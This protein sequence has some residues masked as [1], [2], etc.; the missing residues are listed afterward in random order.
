MT[1]SAERAFEGFAC[2]N[3]KGVDEVVY[4]DAASPTDAVFLATHQPMTIIQRPM[5]GSAEST[6]VSEEDLLRQFLKPGE[7]MMLLPIIGGS[8]TGKSH[9]V[10]WLRA[11]IGTDDSSRRVVYVPKIGTSLRRVIELILDG[12]EGEQAEELRLALAEATD[13]LDARTAPSAVLAALADR[14]EY[15]PLTT[16]GDSEIDDRRKTLSQALPNL[17]RD[18]FF[19]EQFFLREGSVVHQFVDRAMRG[20]R[21]GDGESAFTFVGDELQDITYLPAGDASRAARE[22]QDHL[23][24]ASKASIAAQLLTENLGPA[25]QS[26]FGLEG[27]ISLTDVMMQTRMVLAERGM[28]LI[29]LIEDFTMLQGIQRELLDAIVEP[30]IRQGRANLCGIRVTLAVTSGYWDSLADTVKTRAG[31]ASHVYDLNIP[32]TEGSDAATDLPGFFARYLNA[33]RVGAQALRE[34]LGD[35][36][37][38]DWVPNACDSCRHQLVCHDSFGETAGVGLYP[39]NIDAIHRLTDAVTEA[40]YFDP[41]AVLG[42]IIKKTL[43]DSRQAIVEGRFPDRGYERQ[44]THAHR[45]QR[46]LPADV[47]L[48][49]QEYPDPERRQV[50]LTIWGDCPDEVTDLAEG[51]HEAFRIPPIG[52]PSLRPNSSRAGSAESPSVSKRQEGQASDEMSPILKRRLEMLDAWADTDRDAIIDEDAARL[53]RRHLADSVWSVVDSGV[54]VLSLPKEKKEQLLNQASFQIERAQGG[55]SPGQ[56]MWTTTIKRSPENAAVLKGIL[57]FEA[58]GTWNFRRGAQALRARL[59]LIDSWASQFRAHINTKVGCSEDQRRATFRQLVLDACVLGLSGSGSHTPGEVLNA[60]FASAQLDAIARTDPLASAAREAFRRRPALIE[61]L[62]QGTTVFRGAGKQAYAVDTSDLIAEARTIAAE[63]LGPEG[64]TLNPALQSAIAKLKHLAGA[65]DFLVEGSRSPDNIANVIDTSLQN[66]SVARVGSQA[67]AVRIRSEI[68]QW[69]DFDFENVDRS[70]GLGSVGP[71]DDSRSL[72][73]W[74]SEG[75]G[76][77]MTQYLEFLELSELF[78]KQALEQMNSR[79]R[80]ANTD[81]GAKGLRQ[82][83]EAVVA[84]L[85]GGE[86]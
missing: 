60:A 53:L 38:D 55:R 27:A 79:V 43:E 67:Q 14:I 8:G 45:E 50:L 28:E 6:F 46:A 71:A 7:P 16:V 20:H 10:R 32:M 77:A 36:E 54:E 84:L 74:L 19:R 2:W 66:A 12:M 3:L 52:M 24:L 72:L 44:F 48:D 42:D 49:I 13:R 73:N 76:Q 85:A 29:L 37:T 23:R 18:P 35:G 4:V 61:R 68:P 5:R 59:N 82:R 22:A 56:E 15:S 9:L 11:R 17:L 86:G 30:P 64:E 75:P 41:R 65:I 51:I 83:L 31:F 63:G 47:I 40:S 1:K 81:I 26:V 70:L 33:T 34:A 80:S 39:F 21:P 58:L 25:I 69:R 78:L 57:Q 62:L